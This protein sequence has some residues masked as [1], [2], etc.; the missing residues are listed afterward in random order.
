M[1]PAGLTHKASDPPFHLHSLPDSPTPSLH[2]STTTPAGNTDEPQ[3]P[4]NER[5]KTEMINYFEKPVYLL[6]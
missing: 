1:D 5:T 6:A 4:V 3:I 2:H